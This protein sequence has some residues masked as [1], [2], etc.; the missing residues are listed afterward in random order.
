[1]FLDEVPLERLVVDA[2]KAFEAHGWKS[3][4]CDFILFLPAAGGKLVAAP[5]ELKS[6]RVDVSD[7]LEQ[8]QE[9][10]AFS[11]RVASKEIGTVCRPI[12]I[13]RHGLHSRDRKTLNRTK[14]LFRGVAFT[15]LT[16]RCG[17]P[18]NLANA[19]GM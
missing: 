9:G 6:G 17:R 12:L 16:E 11:E 1:M 15:V 5:I 3:K 10:A 2:D 19:L 14:V 13:H 18:R 8:L 7:A 4:R